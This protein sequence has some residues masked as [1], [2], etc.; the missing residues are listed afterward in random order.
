MAALLLAV[1]LSG[2]EIRGQFTPGAPARVMLHGSITPFQTSTVS[3]SQ[4]RFR[5]KGIEA[6]TYTVIVSVPGRGENRRTIDVGPSV[7]DARNRVKVVFE[8]E[9]AKMTPD[10]SSVVT[11]HQLSVPD[12]ARR[13]YAAAERR[14]AKRDVPGAIAALKRAV[15]I[16]PQF[17]SA[18]NF[19]GTINY[20]T[21]RYQE[22]EQ[23]FRKALEADATSYEPL[24][25]LG[26]VLL[27]LKR[28]D[29][30]YDYNLRA[31]L[32]RPQDA[33]ANSQM[34]LNYLM[35][36]KTDLAE[37]YLLEARRLDPGH[38][39][40]PQMS[41]A[42]IYLRRGDFG[43]AADQLEDFLRHHPDWPNA[44]AVQEQIAKL[45]KA[46]A[47]SGRDAYRK[48]SWT[49]LDGLLSTVSTRS[50][51]PRPMRSLGR[52]AFTWSSPANSCCAPAYS[53]R[54]FSPPTTTATLVS[55]LRLRT[56]VPN[57]NR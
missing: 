38:F 17:T 47:Q 50:T 54:A 12:K 23:Y 20:Q 6:G 35:L 26:G 56:P 30:A 7:A 43:Q 40:L 46:A 9:E 2:Y 52:T 5:F 4:G 25:N 41:L 53:T 32:Q 10:R 21:R 18:W 27:T 3:D 14:L 22:A 57:S 48:T 28:P 15:E 16:A 37:K 42:E 55:E 31:V 19:L 39:S 13:E 44:A 45:R 29:E 51:G 34:G 24:V 1:L 33:L 49:V 36:G 8:L 11:L